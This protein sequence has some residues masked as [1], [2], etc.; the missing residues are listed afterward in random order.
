MEMLDSKNSFVRTR[1]FRLACSEDK[2]DTEN[3]IES[4]I[5]RLL[6][7]LDDPKPAA[8]RQ[9]IAA[10]YT[11]LRSKPGLSKTVENKLDSRFIEI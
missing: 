8:V 3:K 5:D 7:M 10:L 6:C 4:N 11:V 1:G 9:C 2:W